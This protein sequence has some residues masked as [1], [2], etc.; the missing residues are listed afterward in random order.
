MPKIWEYYKPCLL[1]VVVCAAHLLSPDHVIMASASKPENSPNIFLH[2][3]EQ[4]QEEARLID[5][6]C[7]DPNNFW[8]K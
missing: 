8:T 6:F 2:S 1:N 7:Q 5:K 3:K 4:E